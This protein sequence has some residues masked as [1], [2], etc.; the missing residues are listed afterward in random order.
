[1]ARSRLSRKQQQKMKRQ[2]VIIILVAIA[3]FLAFIFV[4]MPQFIRLADNVLNGNEA[5]I[6]D[7]DQVPPQ[8]PILSAPVAATKSASL[9][10]S[11][12]GEAGSKVVLVINGERYDEV[13]INEDGSFKLM[14]ELTEGENSLAVFSID[15]AD[16]ES[17][18]TREYQVDLDTAAPA[19][20]IENP[21]D[22]STVELRKNQITVIKGVTDPQAKVFI[23]D[24]LVYAQKDGSFQMSFKLEEGDN[25]LMFRVEDPAGNT[26]EKEIN[27]KFRF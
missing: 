22:G 19:I 13:K 18:K 5:I 26:S 23:N 15:D 2:T 17:V 9:P 24:R 20:D 14:A 21:E 12:Y 7:Q 11:G 6:T 8:V 3:L 4:I 16:N 25:K 10:L 27:V 1:M